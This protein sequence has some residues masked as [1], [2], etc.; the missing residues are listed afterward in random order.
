MDSSK[1]GINLWPPI[2]RALQNANDINI[3]QTVDV[4]AENS[5]DVET[6]LLLLQQYARSTFINNLIKIIEQK[7]FLMQ[8]IGRTG[9]GKSSTIS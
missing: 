5:T 6:G 9:M 1:C 4:A 8:R 2:N 3:A 7:D